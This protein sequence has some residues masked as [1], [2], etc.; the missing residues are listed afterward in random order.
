MTYELLALTLVALAAAVCAFF[1]FQMASNWISASFF[2]G[3]AVQNQRLEQAIESLQSYVDQNDVARSDKEKLDTWVHDQRYIMLQIYGDDMILYDSTMDMDLSTLRIPGGDSMQWQKTYTVQFADGPG[4]AM[5]YEYFSLRD[6]T[7][8]TGVSIALAAVVFGIVLIIPVRRKAR[9]VSRLSDDLHIL[10]GGDLDYSINVR[11]GDEIGDLAQGIEDMRRAMV[12]RLDEERRMQQRSYELVTAMS[13]D[14]RSPLTS[15]IGYLDILEMN[16]Q[17][18][19]EDRTRYLSN[20]RRKAYR[21][22][23]VS[24]QLFDY[25]LSF[26]SGTSNIE[27]ADY[28]AAAFIGEIIEDGILDL[29]TAGFTV[30]STI[31]NPADSE[32]SKEDKG[33]KGSNNDGGIDP[34]LIVRANRGLVQRSCDN[35]F[36][37][38]RQYADK[39]KPIDI[40]CSQAD[41]QVTIRISNTVGDQRETK[42]GT[43]IGLKT[44]QRMLEACGW[45]FS[46]KEEH[47]MFTVYLRFTEKRFTDERSVEDTEERPSDSSKEEL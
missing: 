9:Y 28:H 11:G 42:S 19:Q 12:S 10:E 32:D 1:L 41:T 3:E 33:S 23:E 29:E 47:G 38:I 43:G 26:D 8:G 24:D 13:H 5:F 7:I 6:E 35:L 16:D 44:T 36:S 21:I 46:Y 15:L 22:K 25:F 31:N 18:S 37:N 20:S 17:V 40:S 45:H 27:L 30:H 39:S 2:S 14:L 34:S 4:S